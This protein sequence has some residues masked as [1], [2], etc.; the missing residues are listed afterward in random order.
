MTTNSEPDISRM[1]EEIQSLDAPHAGDVLEPHLIEEMA[2]Q[3]YAQMPGTL[4]DAERSGSDTSAGGPTGGLPRSDAVAS[5]FMTP[6]AHQADQP[7]F[8]FVPNADL[9]SLSATVVP[10]PGDTIDWGAIAGLAHQLHTR[11]QQVSPNLAREEQTL[12][13][14]APADAIPMSAAELRNVLGDMAPPTH[15]RQPAES[16]PRFYFLPDPALARLR[17]RPGEVFDV[18]MVRKDF[19]ALHQKVHGR[20]LIWL[21]NAATTQKPRDVI[22]AL[23]RFYERDNS[24][25]HRGVHTLA[26]RATD[27]YEGAR[28]KA[29]RFLNASSPSEVIFVHGATEGINLV[30]QTY[31]RKYIGAGDEIVLTMAEHHSNIVPWQ[32][33]A[34]EKSAV[35]RVVPITDRGEV[36]LEEYAR[37]LGPRTRLVALSHVSNALGTVLPIRAMTEMAHRHGARVLIDG[38]QAIP[39]LPVD[40]QTLDSDFYVFSGH[41]LFGPTGIGVLYGKKELLDDMPP[42]QGGGNMIRTV[43]VEETTYDEAPNKFEAGTAILAGA[44]GLC[45]AIDYVSR[46]GLENIARYERNLT[47][48]ATER[49]ALIPGLRQIGTA[50]DKI[51]VLSFVLDDMSPEEVGKLLDL[52]GIAVRAGH[53]CAQPTMRRFG[54]TGTVRPSLA[55]YNTCEE[56]DVLIAA[57][58][59]IRYR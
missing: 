16:Q 21:D 51:G 38:A 24:N 49:L 53:H 43:S 2:N 25:I 10:A 8:Y 19:P 33:L 14:V 46:I 15:H 18:H 23:S 58:R 29:Q 26:T 48:Y 32:L 11:I 4:G 50:P 56:I 44:V 59:N 54:V 57:L 6:L 47:E 3:L 35:L 34:G 28:G 39:H 20:P 1:P 41:K 52:D 45:A 31:G 17:L 40:V 55:F 37:L 9:Q 13:A 22:D 12:S 27:A 30:A 7:D 5:E 36:M 42:W